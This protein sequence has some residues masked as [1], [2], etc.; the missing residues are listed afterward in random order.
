VWQST[1]PILGAYLGSTSNVGQ[2]P[3]GG[4]VSNSKNLNLFSYAH[5]NPLRVRD[6][7]GRQ[8]EEDADIAQ[9]QADRQWQARAVREGMKKIE[10]YAEA[11]AGLNPLIA[12]L[13]AAS[14]ESATGRKLSN[15]E[16]V[17]AAGVVAIGPLGKLVKWAKGL[18][19]FGKA[20]ASVT[21]IA[22]RFA[23]A[24][25]RQTVLESV[26]S[27]GGGVRVSET[28]AKQLVPGAERSFIPSIGILEAI[29]SGTRV[30]DPQGVPGR[31]MYQIGVQISDKPRTLE[32]LVNESAGIVEHILVK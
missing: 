5:L 11:I 19:G 26:I 25:E 2:A 28:V 13:E 10:P 29:G 18:A 6:P 4:G 16:R 9:I 7:D 21:R 30:A 15:E 3:S 24:A 22:S 23:S 32:V 1:D 12:G 17:L 27:A 20:E 31:F 8:T 14:G